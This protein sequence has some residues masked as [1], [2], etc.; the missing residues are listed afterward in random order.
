MS[1][2][3]A[4]KNGKR[5][6]YYVSRDLIRNVSGPK[7]QGWHMPAHEIEALV[8]CALQKFLVDEVALFDQLTLDQSRPNMVKRTFAH[9]RQ[10]AV[11]LESG[12]TAERHVFV[13]D[14]AARVDMREAEVRIMIDL[15]ALRRRLGRDAPAAQVSDQVKYTLSVPAMLKRCGHGGKLIIGDADWQRP[16]QDPALI[17]NI[18]RAHRW[19]G[20]LLQGEAKS[21]RD[22]A[23]RENLTH[24]YVRRLVPLAFLAPDI[25]QAILEGRQPPEL[26]AERLTRLPNLP[27]QWDRQRLLLGFARD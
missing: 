10:I 27:L 5:Y 3:H 8:I 23:R 4:V 20:M 24:A 6:R 9:A 22:L 1:P 16:E 7:Q 21:M 19:L 15:A 12:G 11:A 26:T 17:N 18:V 2:T 14:L 25:T 13:R